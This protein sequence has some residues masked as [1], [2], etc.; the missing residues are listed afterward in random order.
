MPLNRRP[1]AFAIDASTTVGSINDTTA[2][3]ETVIIADGITATG[4]SI[5]ITGIPPSPFETMRDDMGR[6]AFD[7]LIIYHG[8]RVLVF[9]DNILA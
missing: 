3:Y 4:S 7:A 2:S 9:L 8:A 5:F 1:S 6:S